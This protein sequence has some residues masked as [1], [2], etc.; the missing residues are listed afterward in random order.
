MV[1]CEVV[2]GSGGG[3]HPQRWLPVK[4]APWTADKPSPP[5]GPAGSPALLSPQAR[6]C[7]QEFTH[8]LSGW[9]TILGI[10]TQGISE[11][12]FL[13]LL[14]RVELWEDVTRQLLGCLTAGQ[15]QCELSLKST[16][17]CAL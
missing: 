15:G 10:Q 7:W 5:T 8:M 13:F 12:T 2:G 16:R 1:L 9:E 3:E 17:L 4:S 14:C 11:H 6:V